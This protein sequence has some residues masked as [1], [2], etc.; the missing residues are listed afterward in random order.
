M[1]L[2]HILMGMCVLGAIHRGIV[3]GS[4][5]RGCPRRERVLVRPLPLIPIDG[6]V[7]NSSIL[8]SVVVNGFVCRLPFCHLARRCHRS[9][10]NVDRSAVYK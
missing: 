10:V 1:H 7:R 6:Y 9:K 4:S 2:R 8:A 3:D 5:V